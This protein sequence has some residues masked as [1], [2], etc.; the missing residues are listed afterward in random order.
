ML[1]FGCLQLFVSLNNIYV[2]TAYIQ[3]IQQEPLQYFRPTALIHYMYDRSSLV[4]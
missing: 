4:C 2:I 1:D 3:L